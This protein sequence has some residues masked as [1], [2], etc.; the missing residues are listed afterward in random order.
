MT[1]LHHH[2]CSIN[3]RAFLKNRKANSS[4][5]LDSF[6]PNTP[7]PTTF[8]RIDD[9]IQG[10][11]A[12]SVTNRVSEF[13]SK[14]GYTISAPFVKLYTS[15]T[16]STGNNTLLPQFENDCSRWSSMIFV[17][18]IPYHLIL[19]QKVRVISWCLYQILN[20][21]PLPRLAP[22][23]HNQNHIAYVSHR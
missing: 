14:L 7:H 13:M 21:L 4:S 3:I 18:S 5:S 9:T 12:S 10:E 16:G 11:R 22:H 1:A 20:P 23:I 17:P 6:R 8:L 2:E 15:S 19:P